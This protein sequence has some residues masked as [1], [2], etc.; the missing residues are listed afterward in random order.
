LTSLATEHTIGDDFFPP[1]NNFPTKLLAMEHARSN[2]LVKRKE[3]ETSRSRNNNRQSTKMT[4]ASIYTP[5][6]R[7]VQAAAACGAGVF[8]QVELGEGEPILDDNTAKPLHHI[9]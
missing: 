3:D 8:S 1:V 4:A 5:G 9:I 6:V 2:F 7:C